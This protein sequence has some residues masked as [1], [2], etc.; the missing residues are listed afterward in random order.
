MYIAFTHITSVVNP[1]HISM[2]RSRVSKIKDRASFPSLCAFFLCS[3]IY[4][5]IYIYIKL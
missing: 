1:V 2:A 4:I 5:Y 3:D